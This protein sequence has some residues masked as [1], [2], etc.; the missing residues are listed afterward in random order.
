MCRW[1]AYIS[2]TEHCLLED[3]LIEPEHAIARQV[4]E[5]YLPYLDHYEQGVDV[6]DTERQINLR[7]KLFN[8]DGFGI[9]WCV[10]SCTSRPRMLSLR[11]QVYRHAAP[12]RAMQW[13]TAD[14]LPHP[15]AATHGPGLPVDQREHVRAHPLRARPRRVC[16]FRDHDVQQSPLFLWPLCVPLPAALLVSST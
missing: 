5:H 16:D 10:L 7:N 1:F 8:A 4:S 12:V 11:G 3:V 2:E 15:P 13:A 6:A 14:R 9:G